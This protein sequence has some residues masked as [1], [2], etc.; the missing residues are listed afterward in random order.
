[1][2]E[3]RI[4]VIVDTTTAYERDLKIS[5]PKLQSLHLEGICDES[6]HLYRWIINHAP[7]LTSLNLAISSNGINDLIPDHATALTMTAEN[8]YH[9]DFLHGFINRHMERLKHLTLIFKCTNLMLLLIEHIGE[10][11]QLDT[12]AIEVWDE[13]VDNEIF[14]IILDNIASRDQP[15]SRFTWKGHENT[16]DFVL[17]HLQRMNHIKHLTLGHELTESNLQ[18][19]MRL[20]KPQKSLTL[21]CSDDVPADTIEEVGDHFRSIPLYMH[22]VTE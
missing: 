2:E 17:T 1:M 18:Q 10:L 15:L 20:C 14:D 21:H 7:S 5:F 16:L 22:F 3:I 19:V 4:S 13:L 9:I 11:E 12:L 6:R 8:N